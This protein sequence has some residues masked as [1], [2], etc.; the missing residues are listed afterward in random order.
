MIR[1]N[2]LVA[3]GGGPTMVINQSLIGILEE[4]TKKQYT[5][6]GSLNGVNGIINSKFKNLSR[7]SQNS[8][9]FIALSPGAALGS[10]RDKP[11]KDYCLE[12]L[13]NLKKKR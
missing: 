8:R 11:D 12:I 4:C 1:K 5:V 9:N 3:Q 7:L 10:T 13:E 6:L 2:I